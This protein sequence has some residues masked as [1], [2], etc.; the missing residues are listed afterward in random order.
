M[1][2][3]TKEVFIGIDLGTTAYSVAVHSN[4]AVEPL[5][6]SDGLTRTPCF[7]FFAPDSQPYVG[8]Y[9]KVLE[10]T[11]CQNYAIYGNYFKN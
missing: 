3:K 6:D 1:T 10:N 2:E 7:V 11:N 9:A 4:G 5:E 8:L